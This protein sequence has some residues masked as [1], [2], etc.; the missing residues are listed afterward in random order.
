VNLPSAAAVLAATLLLA[1]V[2]FQ[3]LLAAGL[4][5]GHAA[6][7]GQHRVLPAK[8]RR[9][10][11]LAALVL[12]GTAWVV[13]A[14]AGLVPPGAGASWVRGATWLLAASFG[15]NTLGN[16]AS[17]SATERWVMTPATV[18]LV[19]CFLGVALRGP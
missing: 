3:L 19:G 4:P 2:V 17:K 8:L 14:R 9:S 18:L 1:L 15:L 10:S 11:A 16:L 13:L 12:A 6:W 7:G 5:L